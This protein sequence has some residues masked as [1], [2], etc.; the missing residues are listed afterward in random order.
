MRDADQVE[1]DAVR[2][3]GVVHNADLAMDLIVRVPSLR[4]TGG[5]DMGIDADRD[6]G[7]CDYQTSARGP[8]F[9]ESALCLRVVVMLL[10]ILSDSAVKSESGW[11]SAQRMYS[12]A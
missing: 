5:D 9:H 4:A 2:V 7:R 12:T 1:L 6:G 11:L 10:L 3:V 8:D